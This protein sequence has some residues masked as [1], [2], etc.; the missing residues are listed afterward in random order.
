LRRLE[1]ELAET[2]VEEPVYENCEPALEVYA[3]GTYVLA[4][5]PRQK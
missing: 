1:A 2:P 3:E 4:T 5:P